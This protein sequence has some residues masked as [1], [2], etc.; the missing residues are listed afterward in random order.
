MIDVLV[1]DDSD[2]IRAMIIKTLRLAQVPLGTVYEAGNGREALDVLDSNWVDLVLADINMPVMDGVEMV[3]R[4]RASADL[5]GIPVIVVS[6][7][8]ATARIEELRKMGV[9]A[10]VRKPFTPEMLRDVV[11]SVTSEWRT[12]DHETLLSEVMQTVLERFA[13]MY[14]E[15][16]PKDELP[17]PNGPLMIARMTFSGALDGAM[18]LA[19]PQALCREMATNVT[20]EEPQAGVERDADALGEVLNMACGHVATALEADEATDLAPPVVSRLSD[21]DWDR[22]LKAGYTF[23]FTVEGQPVMV[24]LGVRTSSAESA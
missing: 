14:G 8:G 21:E 12:D 5:K 4:M 16:V 23:G 3:E 9:S 10:Y 11:A 18:G 6:T 22:M 24:S 20:G 19:A 7:E 17:R 2:L 13:F 1:V 15:S